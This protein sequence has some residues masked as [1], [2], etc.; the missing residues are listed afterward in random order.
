M[1]GMSL[2]D[3]LIG[4][5]LV[6]IVFVGLL[7]LLRASLL[8]S[9][10]A[11]ARAGATALAGDQMEYVRTLAYDD[12]GTVG[13]I[14][15]GM[16]PAS[17]T[18]SLNGIDYEVRTFI[19]YVDDPA[20]GLG[21]ADTNGVTT[22]YKRVKVAV[23][24][25]VRT[26]PRDVSLVSD[27]APPGIE[28]AVNGGTLNVAVVNAEGAAV[29]GATVRIVNPSA[30][31]AVDFATFSDASGMITLPGAP[32][33]TDYRITV[34]KSGYSSAQTYARDTQN[35]NPAPGYLTIAKDQTTTGTFAIDRLATLALGTFFPVQ[36]ASTTDLF[37]DSSKLVTQSGTQVSGGAL[38]LLPTA[39]VYASS[40]AA[41]AVPVTPA[42]LARWTAA[43]ATVS[44]PSGTTARVR[45]TDAS[46]APLP[47]SALPGNG[48][49][50][51]AF[52]IDLSSVSTTTYATLALK[53][54][55]STSN[56]ALTP[57]VLEWALAY[58]TG[59][60]P[61]PGVSFTLTGAKAVGST[62]AGVLLPK[63]VATGAT[64]ADGT[65]SLSL[66]W[67]AYALSLS[68]YDV[69]DACQAPPF[70]LSPG[71]SV[72]H[73]LF[74]G[75]QTSN[76]VLVTVHAADGSTVEGATATLSR[77]GFTASGTTSACG[78][79]YFGTLTSGTY[80][81]TITKP[82]YTSATYPNVSVSG[83]AFY[84]ASFP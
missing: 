48:A 10:V 40:G 16:I 64:G 61:V 3:V 22:D 18:E 59:P 63:T 46:G 72:A 34:S 54:D 23:S 42:H 69:V 62:D 14:P 19:V 4:T 68:G 15:A 33:S 49:G 71:A 60:V 79:A 82:G 55:L 57:S 37:A 9:G 45:V 17:R 83:H 28:A 43:S 67:D 31:P 81:L 73:T 32:V 58:E 25:V 66:E 41:R 36:P 11:K 1:R 56:S 75:T 35:Q 50:F 13:G 24:Y 7:G 76:A 26:V 70:L 21:P 65:K 47:D 39:G 77:S 2:I 78:A 27:V 6:V 12:V 52:P 74:L 51:S 29:S 84:A 44:M 8:V 38:T 30:S 5:A 53:A 20:D 80:T